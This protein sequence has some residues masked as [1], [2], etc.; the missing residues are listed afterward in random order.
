MAAVRDSITDYLI[1]LGRKDSNLNLML[2]R[3]ASYQLDD[4]PIDSSF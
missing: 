1:W 2:Q 4:N 3:H